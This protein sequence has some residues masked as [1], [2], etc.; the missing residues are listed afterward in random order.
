MNAVEEGVAAQLESRGFATTRVPDGPDLLVSVPTAQGEQ[1]LLVAVK[2][3]LGPS[4]TR[5]SSPQQQSL[6][7]GHGHDKVAMLAEHYVSKRRGEALRAQGVPY[8]DTVG[9]MWLDLPGL[10]VLIEGRPAPPKAPRPTSGDRLSRPSSVRIIFVL[11]TEPLL[12][13]ATLRDLAEQC[14]T[15]IGAA[16]AA[17]ADLADQGFLLGRA[18][19]RRLT[20]TGTLADRWVFDY[21]TRLLP[22]L[23]QRGLRGPSPQ[24]W[25][26]PEHRLPPDVALFGGEAACELRGYPLRAVE[27]LFYGRPPWGPIRQSGRLSEQGD[28]EVT[29]RERFWPVTGNDQATTPSL[30]IYADLG[31]QDDPRL[32][33]MAIQMRRNDD[34]LRRLW[35]T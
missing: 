14:G 33:E 1:T 17:T 23:Q 13:Q 22:K 28:A 10:Y 4:V 3:G 9:N 27:T 8:V 34:D 6:A 30:L 12:L 20:R 11:L 7:E 21:G 29:L 35:P 32:R 2:S 25:T 24:W 31:L 26:E 5:P 15:S 16:Q 18:G 19:K